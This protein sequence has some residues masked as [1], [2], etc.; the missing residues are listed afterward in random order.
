MDVTALARSLLDP[1]PAHATAGL[2]VLHAADAAAEVALRTPLMLTNVIGSLHSSGLITLADAAGL[3]A[4]IAACETEDEMRGVLPLGAAATL[5][6]RAP[7]RGRLVASCRLAE[8]ARQALRPVL[9][10]AQNHARVSTVA[11]I[12]DEAHALVYR[13]TFD[14]SVRRP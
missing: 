3:A 14:W 11:E 5:E 1:V 8:A 12:T 13:G 4:I 10:G 2:E 9:S 6:F 7:A